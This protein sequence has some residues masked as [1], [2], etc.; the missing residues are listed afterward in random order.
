M[1]EEIA[2]ER[3]DFL[4]S[5]AALSALAIL[6]DQTTPVARAD[7][8]AVRVASPSR[9]VRMSDIPISPNAKISVERRVPLS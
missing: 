9:G 2:I 4:K 7:E 5:T 1:D 6:S 8:I 3:R